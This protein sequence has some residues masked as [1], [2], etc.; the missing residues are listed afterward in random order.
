MSVR[1][2]NSGPELTAL[3]IAPDRELAAQFLASIAHARVFQVLSDVKTYLPEQTLEIR[4]R[5]IKPEIVLVDVGSDTDAGCALI[6]AVVRI[7]PETN[8]VAL[9]RESESGA[10]LRALRAGA[11]ECLHAPFDLNAQTE[12]LNRLLKLRNRAPEEPSDA[13]NTVVFSSVKPGSGASTLATQ[14]AFAIRRL[15]GKRVL[16]AD[17]DMTG[18]TIG[19]YLKLSHS[20]SLLDA[21]QNAERL[22]SML[23]NSFVTNCDGVDVLAGP[24]APHADPVEA[25]RLQAVMEYARSYYDWIVVDAP[26]V[27]QR[28]SLVTLS[29]ADRAFLVSTAE[30][31]SLHLAR[32]AVA[33]LEQFGFPKERFQIVVNRVSKKDNITS[34]DMEKLFTCPVQASLPNDYF[35]LHRV[36]TLGQSLGVEGELGRAI[37]GLANRLCGSVA[38]VKKSAT[39]IPDVKL[40]FSL[41]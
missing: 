27:F 12:A 30:L 41:L 26:P 24:A 10:I 4:L 16:L 38:A 31:P 9:H 18:G 35:S 15:T 40:A 1:N 20:R 5:Q 13:A 25:N 2:S 7:S 17:L 33:M 34:A 28:I 11:V 37:H 29:Q 14:T 6:E 32:K 19:F 39:A 21:L 22:D 23:W 3:L 36:V 8:A